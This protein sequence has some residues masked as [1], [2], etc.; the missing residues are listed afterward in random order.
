M[1]VRGKGKDTIV[2]RIIPVNKIGF[3]SSSLLQGLSS[4][5]ETGEDG[6]TTGPDEG[7]IHCKS[8]FRCGGSTS[9]VNPIECQTESVGADFEDHQGSVEVQ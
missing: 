5:L 1:G 4:I 8:Y 7:R 3:P 6:T 2:D 9:D